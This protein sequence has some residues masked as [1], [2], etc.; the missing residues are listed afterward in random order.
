MKRYVALYYDIVD[1]DKFVVA[2]DDLGFS[3][4]ER[5]FEEKYGER[6]NGWRAL[7]YSNGNP[8]YAKMIERIADIID[9]EV[10]MIELINVVRQYWGG[11]RCIVPYVYNEFFDDIESITE[12]YYPNK[13]ESN[14]S[15]D[16]MQRVFMTPEDEFDSESGRWEYEGV[17]ERMSYSDMIG[18]Y[19]DFCSN[20]IDAFN[21]EDDHWT[22]IY[23]N[24]DIINQDGDNGK[25]YVGEDRWSRRLE[26]RNEKKLPRE[27]RFKPVSRRGLVAIIWS[28]SDEERYWYKNEKGEMLLLDYTGWN[29]EQ[30]GDDWL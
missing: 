14:K 16:H 8:K 17:P 29:F 12:A 2:D 11:G 5:L 9:E 27:E 21:T 10:S 22:F 18:F 28:N 19:E 1:I 20:Y 26:K 30:F 7:L 3:G 13:R 6:S 15:V 25:M 23:D 24:G 4:V